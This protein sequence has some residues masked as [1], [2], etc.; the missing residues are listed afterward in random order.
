MMRLIILEALVK[1]LRARILYNLTWVRAM[2]IL[3]IMRETKNDQQVLND[4]VHG[5]TPNNYHS[6]PEY[7]L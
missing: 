4:F 6:T 1:L 7:P 3:Q 2:I 5:I